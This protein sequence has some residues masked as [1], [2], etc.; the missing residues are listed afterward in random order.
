MSDYP[1]LFDDIGSLTRTTQ[2]YTQRRA[3]VESPNN[4]KFTIEDL[5]GYLETEFGHVK[6][7]QLYY[8]HTQSTPS[9]SWSV[10]HNL[11][12]PVQFRCWDTNDDNIIGEPVNDNMD[13][14]SIGFTMA[15]DGFALCT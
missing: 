9:T 7:D 3:S 5:A 13:Q 6:S 2:L 10:V 1:H 8:L 4:Y 14:I 11:N 15:I 12:R